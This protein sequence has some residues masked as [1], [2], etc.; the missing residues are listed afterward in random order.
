M[1]AIEESA[2]GKETMAP[3]R[4]MLYR[5]AW[6][7]GQAHHEVI[8][9]DHKKATKAEQEELACNGHD[10]KAWTFTTTPVSVR[11]YAAD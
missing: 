5:V 9:N 10:P 2:S 8:T 7:D 11:F 6:T 4:M 3:Q 1:G